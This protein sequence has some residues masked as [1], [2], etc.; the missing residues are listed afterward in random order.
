MS[1][2]THINESCHTYEWV[3]SHIW[4]ITC[5]FIW[6]MSQTLHMKWVTNSTYRLL[7]RRLYIWISHELYK[8]RNHQHYIWNGSRTRHTVSWVGVSISESVTDCTNEEITN[9]TYEM[10]HELDIPSFECASGP[11]TDKCEGFDQWVSTEGFDRLRLVVRICVWHDSFTCVWHDSFTHVGQ[12]S[13]IMWG[14]THRYMGHDSSIYGTWLIDICDMTHRC[15]GHH[16][17][18]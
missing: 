15:M 5:A 3:M 4:I 13:S 18:I 16:S 9:T 1:H 6:V 14:M 10:S 8:W 2:V 17:S 11:S 7:S 12:D